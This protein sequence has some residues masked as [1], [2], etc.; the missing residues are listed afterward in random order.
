MRA[1]LLTQMSRLPQRS[2]TWS[3]M[4]SMWASSAVEPCTISASRPWASMSRCVIGRRLGIL[5]V[6]A[7][8][9]GAFTREGL[10][11]GSAD[12]ASTGR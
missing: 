6:V 12:A 10:G 7:G 9:V 1:A 4:S 5:L 11:D 3:A 2:T 8:H